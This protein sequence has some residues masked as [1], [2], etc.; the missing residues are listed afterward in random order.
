MADITK[1]KDLID[2]EVMGDMIAAKVE[3]GITA[4]PYATVDTTL[5]G[6]E[7][8]TIKVAQFVWDGEAVEVPEGTEIPLRNLGSKSADYKVKKIGIGTELSD[9]AVL[10]S[11]GDPIGASVQGI[12]NSILAKLDEDTVGEL[13]KAST[14]KA[15]DSFGYDAIVDG[16]DCF[17]EEENGE[18][19]MLVPP[20]LIS[21]LRKDDDFIDKTKYGNDVMM[22]GEIGMV[23]NVRIKA[24]KRVEGV[25]GF[26]YAPIVKFGLDENDAM[27]AVTYFIK[28]D[29][30]I[31]TDRKS[32]KRTT[33]IT[34]DQL[35]TVALTNDSKVVLVKVGGA[36]IKCKKM[37]EDVYKYPGTNVEL[38]N[39]NISGK[40][41]GAISSS[42]GTYTIKFNGKAK[43]LSASDRTA[44]GFD[45]SATHYLNYSLEIPGAGISD[46]AP[47]VTFGGATVPANQMRKIGQ[48]WYVDSVAAVK[49]SG[50]SIVLASGQSTM[51]AIVC[52]G[53]TSTFTPNF[54]GVTLEA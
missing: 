43:T 1:I 45:A 41:T 54:D 11:H 14:I 22:N 9:E 25:G 8:S 28:R 13:Y 24:S 32:R 27:P 52:G 50:S 39:A 10:E 49:L 26:Y 31:E 51:P 48:S 33:E 46:T 29:T 44:L 53:I 18:K 7:G 15:V 47:T 36:E 34:G 12:A 20:H 4:L 2:P 5:A 17:N 19:G 30:N 42:T 35:Y 3:K 21:A 6:G 16:V 38:A 37:Y 40:V 23:S